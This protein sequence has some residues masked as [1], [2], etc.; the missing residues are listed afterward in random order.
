MAVFKEM[1]HFLRCLG[2]FIEFS[3]FVKKKQKTWCSVVTFE[4]FEVKMFCKISRW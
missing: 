2:S 1:L 4:L 3:E